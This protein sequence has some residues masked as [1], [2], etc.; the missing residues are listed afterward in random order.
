MTSRSSRPLRTRP[1]RLRRRRVALAVACVVLLGGVASAQEREQIDDE[2][3]PARPAERRFET[4]GTKSPLGFSFFG[5]MPYFDTG[6]YTTIQRVKG[7]VGTTFGVEDA[8]RNTLTNMGWLFELGLA[9]PAIDALPGDPSLNLFGGVL[10]P[11]NESSVIGSRV[12]ITT[13]AGT[14][15]RLTEQ[16][17]MQ[18][19]YQTSYRAGLGAEFEFPVMNVDIRVMPGVQYLYLGSRYGAQTASIL[20]FSAFG[21]D[22]IMQNA[23]GKNALVQHFV[24]PSLKLGTEHIDLGPFRF[25][26]YI[27]GGLLVDV[28]GTRRQS[29]AVDQVGGISTY[30]WE[31]DSLAGVFNAGMRVRLR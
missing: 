2:R 22:S 29:R 25:D 7:R 30:T 9:F 8:P 3:A 26:V 12:A 4:G 6:P 19:E 15:N 18:L 28:A 27:E 13:P 20:T 23:A 11:T 24:G 5:I 16:S 21:R 17:K 10:I 1:R 31:A 14:N